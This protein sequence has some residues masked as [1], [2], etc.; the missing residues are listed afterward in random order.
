[1]RFA[2]HPLAEFW[3]CYDAL[4]TNIQEQADRRYELFAANPYHPSLHFKEAGSYWPVRVSR[5]Y[6]ALARRRDNDLYWFWIGSHD[7]YERILKG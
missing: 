6:R 3:E 1:V 5:V 2:S 7:E 4:P